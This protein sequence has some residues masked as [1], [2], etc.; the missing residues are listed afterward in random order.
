[1]AI[2]IYH[3]G[4]VVADVA[5]GMEELT[6][7]TG[8]AWAPVQEQTLKL[9]GP[10]GP[11]EVDLQFTYSTAAPHV[12]LIRAVPGTVW[13]PQPEGASTAHHLGCWSD[14]LAADSARLEAGGAPL[15]VTY[16]SPS[17]GPVG[18]AYHRLASGVL[19]EL[20][21]AA[22]REQFAAWFAGG[23]WKPAKVT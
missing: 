12:E 20:V 7:A 2:E 13:A 4:L 6:A 1:M 23:S 14:D 5:A 17:A 8:C 11:F 16:A 21:D 22:R 3:T 15:L 9:R 19:L 10:E 18:F